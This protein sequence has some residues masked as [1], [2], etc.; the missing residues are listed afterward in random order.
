MNHDTISLD[1][2]VA[3]HD[4]HAAAEATVRTLSKAGFDMAK[5]SI[6]G[7]GYRS[8]EDAL[9]FYTMGDRVRAWGAAGGFWGAVWGLLAGPAV[10]V[11]PRVGL[12]AAAGPIGPALVAAFEGAMVV[13]GVSALCG[14]LASEGLS[15]EQAIRYE[16]DIV[17]DRFLVIVHGTLEDVGRALHILAVAAAP[18]ALPFHQAA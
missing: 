9:G 13:G 7:K 18:E 12:V 14:A 2:V 17:A 6:I 3:V 11:I 16:A 5:L 1:P 8:E 10:F 15:R 4:T